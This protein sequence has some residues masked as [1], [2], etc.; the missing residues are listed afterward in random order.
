MLY[1]FSKLSKKLTELGYKEAK[2]S[3]FLSIRVDFDSDTFKKAVKEGIITFREDGIFLTHGGKEW[4]GYMY[5]PKYHVKKYADFPRFHLT[6][7]ETIETLFTEGFGSLYKWSNNKLNDIV[8]KD[9]LTVYENQK[10]QLCKNCK[11]KIKNILDTEIFFETLKSEDNDE[12]LVI[13][14]DIFGYSINWGKIS[15][16][17]KKSKNYTCEKCGIKIENSYD[18]RFIHTHHKNGSKLNNHKDNLECLCVLCHANTNVAHENNFSKKRMKLET[19]N[20]VAKYKQ[21]LIELG[22]EYI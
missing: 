8:D 18:K 15:S 1:A 2:E 20:F 9:D 14:I 12:P 17:Y 10:L 13:E 3:N 22:N 16:A 4:K 11:K 7:C 21:Q 6:R 19:Q 5:M